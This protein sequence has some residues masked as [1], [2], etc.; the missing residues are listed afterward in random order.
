VRRRL[1]LNA[2][3]EKLYVRDGDVTRYVPKLALRERQ[4]NF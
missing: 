2:F 3:F 1:L 4:G